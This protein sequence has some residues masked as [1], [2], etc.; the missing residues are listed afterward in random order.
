[1]IVEFFDIPLRHIDNAS[2]SQS[3]SKRESKLESS[4]SNKSRDVR[5]ENF[6][7]SYADRYVLYIMIRRNVY[8]V[9]YSHTYNYLP[10]VG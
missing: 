8:R 9:L 7:L 4:G 2:A 6:D 10:Y 5:I 1:M 3:S